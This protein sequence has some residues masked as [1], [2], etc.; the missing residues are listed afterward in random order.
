MVKDKPLILRHADIGQHL[1]LGKLENYVDFIMLSSE[2]I[3]VVETIRECQIAYNGKVN[4][5]ILDAQVNLNEIRKEFK[6]IPIETGVALQQD[7]KLRDQFLTRVFMGFEFEKVIEAQSVKALVA[8]Q[9]DYK[10]LLMAY[11]PLKQKELGKIVGNTKKESVKEAFEKYYGILSE[12][13]SV[14]TTNGRNINM[15]SHMFGY[16]SQALSA[17]E[18][19]LFSDCLERYERDEVPLWVPLEMIRIWAIQFDQE[20]L[21]RQKIFEVYPQTL[22]TE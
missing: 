7:L 10:Y 16:F 6:G 18:R 21:L 13:L 22:K 4:G 9:S 19:V 15:L 5:V 3:E 14:L 11:S 12:A 17:Q 20:Y 1:W 2:T 8:F